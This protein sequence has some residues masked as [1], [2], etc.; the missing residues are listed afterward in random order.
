[1]QK[2]RQLISACKDCDGNQV[3]DV[4]SDRQDTKH[5]LL[6]GE[7]RHIS[8]LILSYLHQKIKKAAKTKYKLRI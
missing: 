3:T 6:V 5:A 8:M 2:R 7:N 1:M 4:D